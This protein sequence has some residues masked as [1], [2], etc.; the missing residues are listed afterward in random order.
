MPHPTCIVPR[1]VATAT[2]MPR[3]PRHRMDMALQGR[4]IALFVSRSQRARAGEQ[5]R[6]SSCGVFLNILWEVCHYATHN[7]MEPSNPH[8]SQDFCCACESYTISGTLLA[9]RLR[10][11][12]TRC[13][14][15]A[16]AKHLLWRNLHRLTTK[17]GEICGLTRIFHPAVSGLRLRILHHI[18]HFACPP[19]S[20]CTNTLSS[21]GLGKTP[22]LAQ[23][24]QAHDET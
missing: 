1:D 24:S 3:A 9:R 2:G 4:S 17:L 16:Y 11:V 8:I 14:P 20:T 22:A 7:T 13:H 12:L 19:T 6:F 10:R 18:R 5:A 23:S 21:G 15:A